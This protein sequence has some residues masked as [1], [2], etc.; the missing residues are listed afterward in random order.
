MRGRDHALDEAVG[1]AESVGRRRARGQLARDVGSEGRAGRR[2]IPLDVGLQAG[3]RGGVVGELVVQFQRI[4]VRRPEGIGQLIADES[5]P[6]DVQGL[7]RS[8]RP[9]ADVHGVDP[10][11]AQDQA[12]V[13]AHAGIVADGRAFVPRRAGAAGTGADESVVAAGGYGRA[14]RTGIVAQGDI[15]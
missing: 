14:R 6:A 13:A 10:R 11:A 5:V 4:A 8:S 12:I 9:D 7:G 1:Q 15:E 3:M 2:R